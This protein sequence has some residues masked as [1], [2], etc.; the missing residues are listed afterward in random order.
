MTDQQWRWARVIF[1]VPGV[2][3]FFL[4]F[5]EGVSPFG[6]VV[7]WPVWLWGY[8]GIVAGLAILIFIWALR[9]T[10]Q[11]QL[12]RPEL[13][14]C[15]TLGIIGSC[16]MGPLNAVF[17]VC[18]QTSSVIAFLETCLFA[19]VYVGLVVRYRRRVFTDSSLAV[20]ALMAGYL[21]TGITYGLTFIDY[22]AIGGY[23]VL[24][25]CL[26]YIWMIVATIRRLYLQTT[27]PESG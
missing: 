26:C 25:A 12:S 16:F 21:P 9:L 7:T 24:L 6:I 11:D 18:L 19:V 4:P 22:L 13:V 3:G 8:A 14:A 17:V 5:Y 15:V 1:S 10:G 2:A 20:A 23:S 27:T